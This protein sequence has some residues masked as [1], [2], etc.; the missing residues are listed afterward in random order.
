MREGGTF[1]LWTPS[2]TT[3]RVVVVVDAGLWTR[4][5]FEVKVTQLQ[6]CVTGYPGPF[7]GHLHSHRIALIP[8]RSLSYAE[9]PTCRCLSPIF[10]GGCPSNTS[11]SHSNPSEGSGGVGK[12]LGGTKNHVATPSVLVRSPNYV[13]WYLII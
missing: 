1:K 6:I 3:R 5:S 7:I 11:S 10:S 9:P 4:K 13:L 8:P 12:Y 2:R